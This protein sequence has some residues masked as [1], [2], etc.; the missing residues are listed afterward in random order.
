MEKLSY[1]LGMVIGHNLKGM[2]VKNLSQDD[3]G[4]AMNDVLTNQTTSL[5][6]QEAQKRQ[7][8][9]F[10]KKANVSSPRMPR[11][12]ALLYCPAVCNTLSS[13]KVQAHS[14]RLP[15]V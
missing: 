15:I 13:P 11:K 14:P 8:A 10:V 7:H 12:K 6:D 5:T 9:K 3:F 2:G 4:K 1:A